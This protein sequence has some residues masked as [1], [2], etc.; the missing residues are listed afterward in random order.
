MSG[1]L[2]AGSAVGSL[3]EEQPGSGSLDAFE[4]AAPLPIDVVAVSKRIGGRF[5]QKNWRK[6]WVPGVGSMPGG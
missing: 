5:G 1:V 6:R 4:C 2:D 3:A